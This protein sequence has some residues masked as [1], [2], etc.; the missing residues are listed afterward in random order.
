MAAW[1]AFDDPLVNSWLRN[2]R[3]RN[4]AEK[5]VRTYADSARALLQATGADSVADLDRGAIET[6][7]GDLAA[8]YKPT[9]VSVR[10]RALQQLYSWLEDEEEIE[11]NPMARLK[12]P[13]VPDQPVPV[14][15]TDQLG[16]L[17]ATCAGKGFAERR[18]AAILRLFMGTGMRLSELAGLAV[19]DLD[20]DVEH[21]AFVAGKGGRMR[22]C[23]FGKRTT[24][25]LDRYL[26]ARTRH[27]RADEAALWLGARG[28]GPMTES[29]IAR[30]VRRRGAEAGIEPLHP[31][32]FR[33]TF[34]HNWLS[35]GGSEGDLMSL[36]GWRSRD[37]LSRYGAS[38]ADQR[39][40][41]AYR[42]LRL[43][44]LV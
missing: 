24:L 5:T 15:S 16:Q 25:A 19:A 21:V 2:L 29:G 10:Y 7:L 28:K 43:D 4:M 13:R 18:D 9:T 27:S 41:D 20:L 26:R 37:M 42:R 8:R 31:H 38:A 33:H 30:V 36:A 14:L 1:D 11:A 12:P 39:A 3:A 34:A 6:F 35:E 40:R 44:D 22:A 32:V 17:L 23:P